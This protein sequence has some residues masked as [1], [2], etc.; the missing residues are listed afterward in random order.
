MYILD[1]NA[2]FDVVLGLDWIRKRKPNPDWDTI[3]LTL[4]HEGKVYSL[5]H[6][7]RHITTIDGE[8]EWKLNT[9]TF[10]EVQKALKHKDVQA[11]LYYVRNV[12]AE[13]E[14][15]ETCAPTSDGSQQAEP[16]G[17]EVQVL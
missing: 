13:A 4:E 7:P 1:L 16:Y 11:V 5:V 12:E 3:M 8:P 14:T 2:E 15:E 9:V 17:P 10:R 6:Y